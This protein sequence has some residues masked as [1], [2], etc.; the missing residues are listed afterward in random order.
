LTSPANHLPHLLLLLHAVERLREAPSSFA[1]A[2]PVPS[3]VYLARDEGEAFWE[4]IACRVRGHPALLF[5][6]V[7]FRRQGPADGFGRQ[8]LVSYLSAP[9]RE[10]A[11]DRTPRPPHLVELLLP[12]TGETV[13]AFLERARRGESCR[14]V[15]LDRREIELA[16]DFRLE[17]PSK[18]RPAG[19]EP[20][21]DELHLFRSTGGHILSGYPHQ[22]PAKLHRA[23]D[24]VALTRPTQHTATLDRPLPTLVVHRGFLTLAAKVTGGLERWLEHTAPFQVSLANPKHM[25]DPL[26]ETYRAYRKRL[27]RG[28]EEVAAANGHHDPIGQRVAAAGREEHNERLAV[29]GGRMA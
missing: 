19:P 22:L 26:L 28:D 2:P 1:A 16:L 25:L 10:V 17:N 24:F 27:M 21:A 23:D 14:T 13:L 15:L 20:E 3:F 4:L 8:S 9:L 11:L 12:D 29:Q 5:G 6:A 7:R 18:S